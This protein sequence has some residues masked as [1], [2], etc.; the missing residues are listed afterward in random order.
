MSILMKMIKKKIK[1]SITQQTKNYINN[2]KQEG[3]YFL[4]N[5]LYIL[6]NTSDT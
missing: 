4:Y 5:C 2:Y 3:I 6:K 1:I